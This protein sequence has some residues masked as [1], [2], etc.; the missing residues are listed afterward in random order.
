MGRAFSGGSVETG[1]AGFA[2]SLAAGLLSLRRLPSD[3]LASFSDAK[4]AMTGVGTGRPWATLNEA[5]AQSNT[6]IM[7][8][9][10]SVTMFCPPG[11]GLRLSPSGST[12]GWLDARQRAFVPL[13]VF[14][15]IT[16][17][18]ALTPLIKTLAEVKVLHAQ[19]RATMLLS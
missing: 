7:R 19:R 10:G 17:R 16:G 11:D 5:S 4:A 9:V 13:N 15:V 2:S 14:P 1:A 18:E 8:V 3:F 12:V 6:A